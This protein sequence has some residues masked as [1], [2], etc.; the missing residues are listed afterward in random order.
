MDGDMAWG[1]FTVEAADVD[2]AAATEMTALKAH[3]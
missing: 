2:A 1:T 3:T